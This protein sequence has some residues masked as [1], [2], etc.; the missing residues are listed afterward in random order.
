MNLN[1]YCERIGLHNI[2][3]VNRS[4]ERVRNFVMTIATIGR[5]HLT[6][7]VKEELGG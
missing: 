6:K 1:N 7:N 5:L 2:N 4:I 3:G